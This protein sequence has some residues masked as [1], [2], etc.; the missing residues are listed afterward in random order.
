MRKKVSVRHEWLQENQLC[1]NKNI[2]SKQKLWKKNIN[3]KIICL[4]L[5]IVAPFQASATDDK[6]KFEDLA[7]IVEVPFYCPPPKIQDTSE[8]IKEESERFSKKLKK[9]PQ[10]RIFHEHY[11]FIKEDF[12]CGQEPYRI[13]GDDFRGFL[14]LYHYD[15]AEY[16][17]T[18]ATFEN[19]RAHEHAKLMKDTAHK[20]L[21]EALEYETK[22][23]N[24]YVKLFRSEAFGLSSEESKS[25]FEQS[26]SMVLLLNRYKSI[27][28]TLNKSLK[29]YSNKLDKDKNVLLL[30]GF[31]EP[32]WE[33]KTTR[34]WTSVPL[35]EVRHFFL[36][37]LNHNKENALKFLIE[38]EGGESQGEQKGR[39][40][41]I[42]PEKKKDKNKSKITLNTHVPYQELR[43]AIRT[44]P[45]K[46][47]MV[48]EL[49]NKNK[50]K[51]LYEAIHDSD[52]VGLRIVTD[53]ISANTGI[54]L[55]SHYG[56][57]I[58]QNKQPDLLTTGYRA[59]RDE[60]FKT[61]DYFMGIYA[62]IEEDRYVR[63]ALSQ[64]DSRLAY[65]SEPN[66]LIKVPSNELSMPYSFLDNSNQ[67]SVGTNS[68]S[69]NK[70]NPHE[71]LNIFKRLYARVQGNP[72]IV[73]DPR[74]PVMMRLPERM[75]VNKHTGTSLKV[76]HFDAQTL[77]IIPLNE[78]SDYS[79]LKISENISQSP[80]SFRD[81][82]IVAYAQLELIGGKYFIKSKAF[83]DLDPTKVKN[84]DKSF[85]SILCTIFNSYDPIELIEKLKQFQKKFHIEDKDLI[86][87]KSRIQYVCDHYEILAQEFLLKFNRVT[88]ENVN[89]NLILLNQYNKKSDQL[90][91]L[92]SIFNPVFK[93]SNLE[94]PMTTLIEAAKAMG[95]ARNN[96]IK[97]FYCPV[98]PP[99]VKAGKK[100]SI[101]KQVS[102]VTR[103]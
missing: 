96:H 6:Q 49:K 98:N 21:H 82:S 86:T 27:S 40:K 2:F 28:S 95:R 62:A 102:S 77:K 13:A 52:L 17:K 79:F 29:R 10:K 71:S 90:I 74:H 87:I 36:E 25:R 3:S 54:G 47:A 20:S 66:F 84:P 42:L 101:Q 55:Y 72:H 57:L 56:E 38:N 59:A 81:Y 48:E 24:K 37:Y 94:S 60:R 46:K 45:L 34:G 4:V 41:G 53:G 30:R 7:F 73:F 67:W 35:K 16:S 58:K 92:E 63:A 33:K 91:M 78:E 15:S 1:S 19:P 50:G 44:H 65:Y 31:W 61:Q 11:K 99:R 100:P 97:S 51:S 69:F 32:K 9:A 83:P 23:I 70:Y 80:L 26:M 68:Y 103:D 8:L 12:N 18:P 64:V 76:G 43:E 5:T 93:T 88:D 75:L 14:K 89:A 85:Y 22:N 39:I